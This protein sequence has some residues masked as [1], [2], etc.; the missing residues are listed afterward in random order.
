MSLMKTLMVAGFVGSVILVEC[1]LAYY[2][3]PS[4]AAIEAAAK[5][6][7]EAEH[8]KGG[9]HGDHGEHGKKDAHGETGAHGEHGAHHDENSSEEI[10]LGKFN[11]MI[12]RP[13]NDVTLRV[14]FHL[15]GTIKEKDSEDFHHMLEKN[16]HRLR[17]RIIFEIRNSEIS[18][19]T[20]PGLGLIKRRI[21]AKSNELLGKPVLE[22][23]VFSEFSYVQL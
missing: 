11:I 2:M 15:I 14:S 19:L 5:A 10:D 13:S 17:D 1:L 23:V 4:T 9:E 20:D 21:L 16:E 8:G 3:I 22:S 12:H 7:L 6:K 18:D